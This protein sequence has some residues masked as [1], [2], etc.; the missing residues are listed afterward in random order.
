GVKY[1]YKV[2]AVNGGG[3]SAEST[4]AS[5]TPEPPAPAAPTGLTATAGNTQVALSWTATTGATTYNIYRATT[6]GG[7]GTTA[8]V[9]GVTTAAYTDTGLT[10]GT[11][12][13]YKVAAVNGGGTSPQSTE[14][15]ATPEP[16]APAAPTGLTATA[17][18][19]QVALSWTASTGSTSYN[20]YRG[21]ATG[22]EG[23]TAIATGITGTAYTNT[24]LTNGTTYFYKVAGINAGGTSPLS[25]EASA[26]PEPPAPAAPTGLTATAGNAQ[27]ALAWTASTGAT[28]YNVYRGTATGG[29]SAT[30]IA[31]G[32]TGASYTNTGLTNGTT[33]FYKVAGVNGGGTSPL[34]NEASATPEPPIPAAPTGLT[35]TAGN[36]QVALSWTASTGAT[37]YNLYRGTA[38]GAEAATAIVTGI[39][40]VTYTNMSLTNGVKYFYKVAALNGGGTSPQSNEASATPE[41]PIP[42][43]PAGLT[44]TA[45]NAQVALAWTASTGATTYNLYR[46]T[47]TGA[48]AATAIV[49]GITGTTYTNMS[50][51][52][53]TT[54]FFKVAAVNGG[55]TSPQSNE[56]SATPEP[57]I[58][59]TP[60]GLTA[61]AGNAQVALAW[62]ASTGATTYNVYRGTATGGESSTAIAT[63]ITGAAYTNTGLTNG[64]TYF[65]KVAAVNGGGT[66]ALSNEASA[67]PEPP[68]PA[69]PTALTAA[70][71]NAQVA[72]AWTA[73]TGATTYNVYR[74]TAT[75][76]EASTAI[77]TG[78][79]G[80]AYTNTGLTNGTTYFYKVAAV[81]GGG[82]SPLSNEA[83]ATPEPPVPAAPTALAAT[84]GNAQVAL[85]WVA[86]F[87][88]TSYDV[89]RG[90]ASNAEGSTPVGTATSTAYTDTGLTN[91]TTYYYK[92]AA[93]NGGG[94][95][96]LS[97]ETSAEPVAPGSSLTHVAWVGTSGALALWNYTPATGSFTQN[98]YGPFDGWSPTAIADGPDG[99]TRVM[100]VS[101]TGAVSI[102]SLNN[103][104]GAYTQFSFGPYPGWTAPA[105]SVGID[106]TTH[107]LW[108]SSTG[109]ASIWNYSTLNGTET[110]NSYGPYPDYAPKAIADGPDGLMRMI[111]VNTN[112]STSIWSLNN[113]FASFTENTFTAAAGWTANAVS[114]GSDNTTHVLW[115]NTDGAASLWN[116]STSTGAF[117]QNTYGPFPGYAA[118]SLTDASDGT[119]RLLWDSTTGAASIWDLDNT[120]GVFTQNS[121]GPF[122]DFSATAVSAYPVASST[123]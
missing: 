15:S 25:T 110:Q 19:S 29:E 36:S 114:V 12:Y 28:T 1:F 3:T 117:T 38:T 85:S 54:Y 109:A 94:T 90:T 123:P 120:T 95:S 62:T 44:A 99:M 53:G 10:N 42:S 26:T 82:T 80:A 113:A 68:I 92:V 119:T 84:P 70:A 115:T 2:A 27:V 67:T 48:E 103:V 59:S 6:T 77:A 101:T 93:V 89:Y 46:G 121:F 64:T 102:W 60:A 75:G 32:I 49:T 8:I 88:A 96:P 116:Y 9:T 122:T 97:S 40:G 91:G 22:G 71:G 83:S 106:N 52:N 20:V 81:N 47:A 76:G 105:M 118:T 79:T 34:S 72:L 5:A 111:W 65:Y 39:T 13:F 57:P 69:A 35:A 74:G 55:G 51:T 107:V 24:G 87:G 31:T 58:P 14:A 4:E 98:V 108:V 17:G 30:A 37:T 104:T 78:I 112:G 45:S 11:A 23:S 18:N 56:A 16:P 73:S 61:T 66:S 43:T 86:S 21:T 33:Y 63:G 7:E 50:L 100:W 41:P